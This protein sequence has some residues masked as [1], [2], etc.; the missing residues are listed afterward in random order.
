MTW[1]PR[2][3]APLRPDSAAMPFIH[4]QREVWDLRD[5]AGREIGSDAPERGP[6]LLDVGA[7]GQLRL[8]AE[9]VLADGPALAAAA[10]LL[11]DLHSTPAL[12]PMICDQVGL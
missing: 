3:A 11:L 7:V 9:T 5:G 1:A 12:E 8:P 2:L 6:W 4:L 10:R